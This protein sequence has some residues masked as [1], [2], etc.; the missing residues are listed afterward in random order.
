MAAGCGAET[1]AREASGVAVT[2][3]AIGASSKTSPC[4]F[5][6]CGGRS[7]VECLPVVQG[8]IVRNSSKVRTRGLQHFQP[9]NNDGQSTRFPCIAMES[10]LTLLPLMEDRRTWMVL[11]FLLRICVHLPTGLM[12]TFL[13]HLELPKAESSRD[14][15][16][17]SIVWWVWKAEDW[18]LLLDR[19]EYSRVL[20][21]PSQSPRQT[22]AKNPCLACTPEQGAQ[23]SPIGELLFLSICSSFRRSIVPSPS[24]SSLQ[25]VSFSA[26]P[27]ACMSYH[28][29][30]SCQLF[31]VYD[32][33]THPV[34]GLGCPAF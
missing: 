16:L 22:H 9:R 24:F 30:H 32:G 28:I 5:S 21:R 1:G 25:H 20:Y 34:R 11:A 2:G 8:G 4:F 33:K 29:F 31:P 7:V 12:N 19:L 27:P 26:S 17:A 3:L 10:S 13:C 23:K 15:K 6:I 14:E 18:C